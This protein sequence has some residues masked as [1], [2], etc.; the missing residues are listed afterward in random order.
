MGVKS[1]RGSVTLLALVL[2]ASCRSAPSSPPSPTSA[3]GVATTGVARTTVSSTP[4]GADRAAVEAAYRGFWPVVAS[5]AQLPD[6]RWQAALGQVATA[7]Q[8]ALTISLT[9]TQR[10]NGIAVYGQPV[11]RAPQAVFS[12]P[13]RAMVRDC[14]DFSRTGQAD[15]GTGRPKTVGVA[16]N[17]VRVTL[18]RGSDGRWRVDEVEYPGGTC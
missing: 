16:R 5:F 7:R 14:A 8:S 11:P 12:G 17:P 6:S 18:V 1:S 2:I 4:D 9:R 15:A 13:G 3:S 10:R